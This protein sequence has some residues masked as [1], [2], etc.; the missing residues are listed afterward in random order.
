MTPLEQG[1]VERLVRLEEQKKNLE[2]DIAEIKLD[3]KS[4]KADVEQ[5]LRLAQAKDGGKK[6]W[7]A[8]GGIAA[9]VVASLYFI[10]AGIVEAVQFFRGLK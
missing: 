3:L 9:A 8:I 5:L 10:I 4:T 1:M 2:V 6:T 7:G